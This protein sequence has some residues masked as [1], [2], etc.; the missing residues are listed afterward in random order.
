MDI[1]SKKKGNKILKIYKVIEEYDIEDINTEI[2]SIQNQ[3]QNSENEVKRL[4]EKL[5]KIQNPEDKD[6]S[7]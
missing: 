7:I 4:K 2:K 5:N 3:I 6:E 1:R